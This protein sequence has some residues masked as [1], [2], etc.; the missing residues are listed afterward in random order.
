MLNTNHVFPVIS[1]SKSISQRECA[2][3]PVVVVVEAACSLVVGVG[4]A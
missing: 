4:P 1:L 3:L 2:G